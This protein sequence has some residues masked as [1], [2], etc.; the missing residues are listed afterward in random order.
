[1]RRCL[2]TFAAITAIGGIA[3]IVT[4]VMLL[5]GLRKEMEMRMEPWIWCMAI[6][7]VWR[8]LVII[9]ASIVNDMIFAYHIL[10]CL[11]WICFIGGNIFSWLVVH[12]FYHELCEVTRL[13]DCA[14]AK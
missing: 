14:R 5:Q 12:S 7:T 8:S 3:L 4:A 10:M 11:F 2:M 6:F 13:E 1:V 9:F